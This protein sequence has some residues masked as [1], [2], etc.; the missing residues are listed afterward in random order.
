L[1]GCARIASRHSSGVNAA[2]NAAGVLNKRR[3]KSLKF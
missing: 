3:Y 2:G 1:L